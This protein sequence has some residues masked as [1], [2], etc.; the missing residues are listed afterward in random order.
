MEEFFTG[1]ARLSWNSLLEELV[2]GG[3]LHWKTQLTERF[4]TEELTGRVGLWNNSSLKEL[5][6]KA[7]PY[8]RSL[9]EELIYGRIL[10]RKSQFIKEF[11]TKG[12]NLWRD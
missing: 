1:R 12:A 9:L 10:D 7:I 6:P 8:R 3:T 11:L 2:Y 5:A 4:L